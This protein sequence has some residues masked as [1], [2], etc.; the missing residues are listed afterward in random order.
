MASPLFPPLEPNTLELTGGRLV[1]RLPPVAP[2]P[3]GRSLG[4]EPDPV[5]GGLLKAV[6]GLLEALLGKRFPPPLPPRTPLGGGLNAEGL[7]ALFGLFPPNP[8]GLAGLA[9]WV[10]KPEGLPDPNAELIPFPLGLP[11]TFLFPSGKPSFPCGIEL[12]PF[13][14]VA[15][16]NPDGMT[17][18]TCWFVNGLRPPDACGRRVVGEGLLGVVGAGLR[19]GGCVGRLVGG[20]VGL[21]VGLREGE[22]GRGLAVVKAGTALLKNAGLLLLGNLK[23]FLGVVSE[24]PGD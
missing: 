12:G 3:D 5:F 18:A 24:N 21:G 6:N 1:G 2:N 11:N 7:S 16:E 9:G 14:K 22:V 20:R 10:L 17:F 13:D 19:V 23:L 15:D 8:V 4:R